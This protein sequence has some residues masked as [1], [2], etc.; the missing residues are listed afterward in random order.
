MNTLRSFED[1]DDVEYTPGSNKRDEDID[2]DEREIGTNPNK[3]CENGFVKRRMG[4]EA[5]KTMNE[6][7]ETIDSDDEDECADQCRNVQ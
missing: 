7:R 2:K 1:E 6:I 3:F 5:T 4:R